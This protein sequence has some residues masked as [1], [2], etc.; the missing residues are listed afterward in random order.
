MYSRY[1]SPYTGY[2]S[3]YHY[4]TPTTPITPSNH[5]TPTC[6]CICQNNV[7][8]SFDC[9][10]R[11]YT[12]SHL[13]AFIEL[14]QSRDLYEASKKTEHEYFDTVL[15]WLSTLEE[16]VPVYR[17]AG[18]IIRYMPSTILVKMRDCETLGSLLD[19]LLH[20]FYS[21]DWTNLLKM[22][23]H[24]REKLVFDRND[25]NEDY[26]E[27]R[28]VK[29]ELWDELD[30]GPNTPNTPCPIINPT[31]KRRRPSSICPSLAKLR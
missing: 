13:E 18:A 11:Y 6:A 21:L 19:K 9:I 26:I 4:Q 28:E 14:E 17:K 23:R 31:R 22:L 16:S 30:D 1:H 10:D 24:A 29:E 15:M 20:Y 12:E 3:G 5:H 25:E 8:V 27:R 7:F 2:P